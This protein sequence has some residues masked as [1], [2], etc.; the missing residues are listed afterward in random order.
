M[1]FAFDEIKLIEVPAGTIVRLIIK[2]TLKKRIMN[3][4]FPWWKRSWS[5]GI[6]SEC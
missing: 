4:L 6:K 2:G 3:T 1:T 5:P